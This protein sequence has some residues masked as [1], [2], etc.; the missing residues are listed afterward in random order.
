M[1]EALLQ[2][3]GITYIMLFKFRW[4]RFR[5]YTFN[6]ESDLPD[7]TGKVAIVTGSNGGIGYYTVKHLAR[8]GATVYVAARNESKAI[9]AI[10]QLKQDGLGPGN[11]RFKFLKLDLADPK[12]VRQALNTF[13]ERE[14]R[15]DILGLMEEP[16]Q[17]NRGILGQM[18]VNHFSPFIWTQGLLPLLKQTA[19]LPDCHVRIVNVS[20]DAHLF[21]SPAIRFRKLA[22]FNAT[23]ADDSAPYYSRYCATKLANVLFTKELQRRLTEEDHRIMITEALMRRLFLTAEVGAYTTLFAAASP[24]V[25]LDERYKGGYLEP[26]ARLG[27]SSDQ[28]NDEELGIELW[29]TTERVISELN[30]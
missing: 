13:L 11:G 10:Q 19:A 4:D 25:D 6:P 8:R 30:L 2:F 14:H 18:L 1:L 28:A 26:I 21:A 12:A 7:L 24:E 15:L 23:Y 9:G 20:S 16:P 27:R 3:I 29:K 5:R 22:D 17:F